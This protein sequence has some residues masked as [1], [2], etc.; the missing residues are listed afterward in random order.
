MVKPDSISELVVTELPGNV[1]ICVSCL[2]KITPHKSIVCPNYQQFVEN[3]EAI[4]EKT[5]EIIEAIQAK[6]LKKYLTDI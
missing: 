3:N 6:D 5:P 2:S 1:F 4:E